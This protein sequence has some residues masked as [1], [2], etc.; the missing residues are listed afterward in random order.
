MIYICN[1][2]PDWFKTHLCTD[3]DD[4]D[5]TL[6]YILKVSWEMYQIQKVNVI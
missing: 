1:L 6:G 2:T 4:I 3:F 5:Q